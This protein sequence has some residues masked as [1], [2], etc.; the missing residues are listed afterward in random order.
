MQT[1]SASLAVWEGGGVELRM[2]P[3][4]LGPFGRGGG[5]NYGGGRRAQPLTPTPPPPKWHRRTGHRRQRHGKDTF[6]ATG[7][8]INA[9][10]PHVSTLRILR[11]LWS[12]QSWM[13]I[14]KNIFDLPPPQPLAPSRRP[15]P[16]C[17]G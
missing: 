13:K 7:G 2:G 8:G 11:V 16:P 5:G 10:S 9:F 4:R 1:S 3:I 15:G 6:F 17:Q 14:M 12:I